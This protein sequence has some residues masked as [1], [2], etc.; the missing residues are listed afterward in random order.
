MRNLKSPLLAPLSTTLGGAPLPCQMDVL[1][2]MSSTSLGPLLGPFMWQRCVLLREFLLMCLALLYSC[3]HR[4]V[5]FRLLGNGIH[6]SKCFFVFPEVER[7]LESTLAQCKVHHRQV[8]LPK[9]SQHVPGFFHG[10][11][12]LTK[13]FKS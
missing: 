2:A 10:A 1:G 6:G 8:F 13:L 9:M 4:K 11:P 12:Y 3:E 5:C 7:T